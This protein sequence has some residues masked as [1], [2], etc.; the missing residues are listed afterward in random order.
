MVAVIIDNYNSVNVVGHHDK[1]PQFRVR[2]MCGYGIPTFVGTFPD[3]R[4]L[5]FGSGHYSH[6]FHLHPRIHIWSRIRRRV[7]KFCDPTIVGVTHNFPEIMVVVVV[8]ANGDKIHAAIVAMPW[9][10]GGRCAIFVPEFVGHFDLLLCVT[11]I[12]CFS[13]ISIYCSF[14]A[15]ETVQWLR[16]LFG[17]R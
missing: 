13:V 12:G 3:I 5:H 1:R 4:Q 8:G 7:A 2:K 17:I 10:A 16:I 6:G 15:T 11:N 14:C 9:G